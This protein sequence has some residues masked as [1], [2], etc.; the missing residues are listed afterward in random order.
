MNGP[1][2][3]AGVLILISNKIDFQLE[4]IKKDE[5]HFLLIKR[6]MYQDESQF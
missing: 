1:K 3:Q 4:A 2:K 6:K 5:G